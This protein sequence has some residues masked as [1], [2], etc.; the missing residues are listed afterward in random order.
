MR[1]MKISPRRVLVSGASLVLAL[2]C[3]ASEGD[4]QTSDGWDSS[5]PMSS[6]G[7]TNAVSPVETGGSN[8]TSGTVPTTQG[9][10]PTASTSSPSTDDPPVS[11]TCGG[12]VVT[13]AKRVVRLSFNQLSRTL[14][15]LLGEELGAA[16][17]AEFQIGVESTVA[18]TFPPL[19]SP[20]EGSTI[21]T[22]LWQKVNLI[23]THAG[24]YV[25]EHVGEVTGC[26]QEMSDACARN[27]VTEFAERAFRRP[28]TPTESSSVLAVYDE[29]KT[30]YGTVPEAVQYSVYAILQSPQFLYR[31]ELGSSPNEAGPLSPYEFASA[32][33]YFL[34]DGPPDDALLDA[35]A[36]NQLLTRDQIS[37]QVDRLLATDAA[38]K[39]LE[40][41][42]FSY[43]QLDTLAS[44][45]IDDPAFTSGTPQR[46]YLGV[47]ESAYR[48]LE[49]FLE[50]TLWDKPL[51]TLLTSKTSYIN[52][53]LAPLYGITLPP[54]S[55]EGQFVETQ[56]PDNRAGILTQVG[57]LA[58][59]S[60]PDVPSV[61][62]RGLVVNK[63][64]LCQTNPPFPEEPAFV[65]QIEEAAL[66]LSSATERE[67]ADY[68][69]TTSPCLGCHLVFDAY[70]L[71][72]DSYDIIGRYRTQDPEGRDIDP[73]VT[74]PP[75]FDNEVAGDAVEMQAKIAANE[76][77]DACF[78]RNMLNWALAEGSQL[79]PTSCATEA[80]LNNYLK[81][82]KTLS[83]LLREVAV[84]QSFI[85]RKAGVTP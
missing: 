73:S 56:L 55:D 67:R 13:D 74:L 16:L 58:S 25:L 18:R 39:N 53:T 17:D 61:V 84:S 31:T 35:A 22:G 2:G 30:I 4:G 41:A 34:T 27:F 72:L 54:Q 12:E 45:K 28:L 44:V 1:P 52:E 42:L 75:L 59:N 81:T 20:Q 23:A 6:G 8:A 46:P 47:R 40:G 70:G 5:D 21:T 63:T 15:V 79:M 37:A 10:N 19:S 82:D 50:N 71:A 60:R 33:S 68:R 66:K 7:T 48:E 83:D 9:S 78:S 51:S 49:L 69:T 11:S 29:V 32:L 77:F 85:Q 62:A 43:F 24:D 64:M 65:A 80:I 26:G 38:R 76:G 14:R 36:Q 57:F 3:S